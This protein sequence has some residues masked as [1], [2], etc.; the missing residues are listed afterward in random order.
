MTL[1]FSSD[2][3][4]KEV[5]SI[6]SGV[7]I[8]PNILVA[9]DAPPLPLFEIEIFIYPIDKGFAASCQGRLFESVKLDRFNMDPNMAFQAITW[10][11]QNLVI[12][13]KSLF[14]EQLTNIAKEITSSFAERYRIYEQLRK[15][16]N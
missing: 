13:P 8:N 7:N 5:E 10:E 14:Q 3:I 12:S 11:K 2:Q 16:A 9:S 6:L 4:K 15:N 1:D